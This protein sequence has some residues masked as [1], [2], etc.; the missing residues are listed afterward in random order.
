VSEGNFDW[1]VEG[2]PAAL[3]SGTGTG[4]VGHPSCRLDITRLLL[5]LQARRASPRA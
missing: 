3:V 4:D 2:R 5:S 1:K